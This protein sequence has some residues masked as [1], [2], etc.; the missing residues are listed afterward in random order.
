MIPSR[1][2]APR[3]VEGQALALLKRAMRSWS[4]PSIRLQSGA[5]TR[6]AIGDV[7]SISAKRLHHKG[8]RGGVDENKDEQRGRSASPA[9]KPRPGSCCRRSGLSPGRRPSG[10]K[11]SSS[12]TPSPIRRLWARIAGHVFAP[13]SIMQWTYRGTANYPDEIMKARQHGHPWFRR[14]ACWGS[15]WPR[16]SGQQRRRTISAWWFR[17]LGRRTSRPPA[18][19]RER[20]LLEVVTGRA[21][22][23]LPVSMSVAGRTR[24]AIS[25]SATQRTRACAVLARP[26][27]RARVSDLGAHAVVMGREQRHPGPER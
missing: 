4:C 10:R 7:V 2:R 12:P 6:I 20:Y 5:L 17:P 21:H 11:H 1:S 3:N 8:R 16:S 15:P 22:R 27:A 19:C 24:M 26:P 13:W 14:W 9:E 25:S 18:C 23:P